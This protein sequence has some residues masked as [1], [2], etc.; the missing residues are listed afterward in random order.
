[1]TRVFVS[2]TVYDL[3]DAR[4]ELEAVLREM[5]L[6]PVLSESSS[7]DFRVVPD[8]NSIE[9]CLA[10]LRECEIVILL[11][12]QRYGR[13]VGLSDEPSL[14]ATHLEYREARRQNKTLYVYVRDRLEGDFTIHKANPEATLDFKWTEDDR[15]GLFRL[16]AEHRKLLAESERSNW[17]SVFRNSVELK[18]LV[19]RDLHAVA[20]RSHLE[21]LIHDNRIPFVTATCE[22]DKN[23]KATSS[24]FVLHLTL[25]NTGSAPAY[26][27][28]SILYCDDAVF[29][30]EIPFLA[31]AQETTR[32][33]MPMNDG[34]PWDAKLEVIYFMS[35]GHKVINTYRLVVET[36]SPTT[37]IHGASSL[38]QVFVPASP[39]D[40]PF[41]IQENETA[42][43]QAK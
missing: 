8:R 35:Y 5:H 40:V 1:M 37:V 32:I 15:E 18:Q 30:E 4:A 10:N 29:P 39:G 36:T 41:L 16:L 25:R 23:T 43:T 20:S 42:T 14:S 24:R 11:L 28:N 34:Q 12:S 17:I 38:S 3:M 21:S 33:V 22:L 19:R 9:C 27:C 13:P 7:A 26:R 6:T 2:S 31:P